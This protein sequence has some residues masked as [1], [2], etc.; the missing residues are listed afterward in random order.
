MPETNNNTSESGGELT[1]NKKMHTSYEQKN[2]HCKDGSPEQLKHEESIKSSSD[3]ETA[4]CER[5]KNTNSE[6][7]AISTDLD[8]S[9]KRRVSTLYARLA[10]ERNNETISNIDVHAIMEMFSRIEIS[11]EDLFAVSPP[12]EDCDICFLPMPHAADLCGVAK[13]YMPCCGKQLCHGCMDTAVGEMKRGNIKKWCPYCRVPMP[14][15]EEEYMRRLKKRIEVDDDEAFFLL[16]IKYQHGSCG[17]PKDSVKAIEMYIQAAYLGSCRAHYQI[18]ISYHHFDCGGVEKNVNK[19]THHYKLAAIG[20]H[21]GARHSLGMLGAQKGCL[22]F[23]HADNFDA[24]YQ[25]FIIG[26]MDGYDESLK[27]MRGGYKAGYITKDGYADILRAYQYISNSM[28]SEQRTKVA[29][30]AANAKKSR[31]G[32]RQ[33]SKQLK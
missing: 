30:R 16:G 13:T 6:S 10:A 12:K 32:S 8:V 3:N 5:N 11:D 4:S 2:D 18:A 31:T 28:K 20:G 9:T 21:E 19:A 27:F 15:T 33:L 17:L 14:K 1:A 23:E 29:T 22:G 25:H 24:A 7:D 26:A